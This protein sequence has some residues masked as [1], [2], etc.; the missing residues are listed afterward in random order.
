[1]VRNQ[2]GERM[3]EGLTNA[4]I[5]QIV[6]QQTLEIN[7]LRRE[8]NKLLAEKTTKPAQPMGEVKDGTQ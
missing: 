5:A 3:S 8:L 4:E 7:Y 1:M 6:G 2:R